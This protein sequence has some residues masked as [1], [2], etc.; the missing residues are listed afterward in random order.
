LEELIDELQAQ[1]EANPE[2]TL[3]A[4]ALAQLLVQEFEYGRAMELLNLVLKQTPRDADLALARAELQRRLAQFDD[5]VAGYQQILRFP[6]I[7]RD[8][9]LGEFYW[10]VQVGEEVRIFTSSLA[11]PYCGANTGF[12]AAQ[13]L[14][15]VNSASATVPPSD[16]PPDTDRTIESVSLIALR[17][18]Q[19][20][21]D[22]PSFGLL[23]MGSP[24]PRRFHEGMATDFLTQIASLASAA[25]SRLLPH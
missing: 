9:V 22:A 1:V 5:S 11:A 24:D 13:W 15:A 20:G 16:G 3:V 17:D 2:N 18:P 10:R 12:A 19:A 23:V 6:Q 7:D 8:Y 14:G 4:R 25:L 21:P